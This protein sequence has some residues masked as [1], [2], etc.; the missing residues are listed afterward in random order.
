MSVP[1]FNHRMVEKTFAY[2]PDAI[3]L[4]FEDAAQ[5]TRVEE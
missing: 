5:T 4:D 3:I 2:D 1:G